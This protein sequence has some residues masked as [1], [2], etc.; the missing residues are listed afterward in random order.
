M[1]VWK[2][3]ARTLSRLTLT[4]L[5]P[6]AASAAAVLASP[7]ALVVIESSRS[8]VEL[9]H[10]AHD[11]DQAAPHQRLA[12]GEPDLLDPESLDP[13]PHQA[14]HL[15]VGEHLVARQPVESLGG[16][17]VGAAQ[18]AAVGQR[19]AEVAG[20]PA[21]PV[22]ERLHLHHP[23]LRASPTL[24][25]VRSFRFLLSRRWLL[26]GLVVV[27]LAWAAWWL[28]EWQFHRLEDRK[29]RN[30]V[31]RANEDKPPAPVADVLAPGRAVAR[32]RGVAGGQRPPAPTTPPTR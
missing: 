11:L 15:V 9:T 20:D 4:R 29:E 18:V 7:R 2:V 6:A 17:A 5:S 32:R 8:G 12:A 31:V 28:G 23:S 25:R 24:S 14:H 13:D 30:A 26:F 1:I 3:S 27:L 19:H 10:L 22:L 21:V 16:H